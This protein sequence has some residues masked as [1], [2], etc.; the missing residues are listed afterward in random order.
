MSYTAYKTTYLYILPVEI[1][2]YIFDIVQKERKKILLDDLQYN[3]NNRLTV[4][5]LEDDTLYRKLIDVIINSNWINLHIF[6]TNWIDKIINQ[7]DN[8]LLYMNMQSWI[9]NGEHNY[10]RYVSVLEKILLLLHDPDTLHSGEFGIRTRIMIS[11]VP[12]SYQELLSLCKFIKKNKNKLVA[13]NQTSNS[14]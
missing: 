12:L 13:N 14:I 3:I 8:S 9:D 1:Q 6:V 11:L 7:G 2:D 10:C 5:H 4:A